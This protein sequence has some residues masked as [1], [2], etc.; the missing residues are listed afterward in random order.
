MSAIPAAA[1]AT[2]QRRDGRCVRCGASG[3]TQWH[4]RRSRR[5]ADAHQH[6]ACNGV[7]VC[8]ACHRWAH[9]HPEAARN[10]GLIVSV[11][12]AEPTTIPV[13]TYRGWSLHTCEGERQAF[14][15]P[16]G[17]SDWSATQREEPS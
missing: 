16:V 1:R 11:F 9:A 13:K 2:V 15:A 3:A 7:T 5:V 10:A 4:H 14:P 8:G 17:Q 12:I 6:C